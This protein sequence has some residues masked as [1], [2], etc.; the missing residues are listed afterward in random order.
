MK[1]TRAAADGYPV[2]RSEG[3]AARAVEDIARGSY[4]RLVAYLASVS[5]DIAAAEDALSEAFVAA[6]RSWPE[7]GVPDRPDSWLVTAA[8]RTL[9]DAARRRSVAQRGL[10]Q[11]AALLDPEPSDGAPDGSPAAGGGVIPDKRLELMFACTHPAIDPWMRAPL[12]LQ[13]VLGI[14]AGRI[15]AAFLVP[16]ATMGQRL[17]RAKAK[18]KTAAVPFTVPPADQLAGRLS[19]VL[20]AVFAAYGTGWD[21]LDTQ[22]P[23][24]GA[25]AGLTGEALRLATV[26]TELLPGSAEAHGLRALLL[27]SDARAD[28]RRSADGAFVPLD[29]QDVSLWS[30]AQMADAEGHLRLALGLN[31]PAPQLGPYQLQ[32]AVQSVHNRRALTGATDWAAVAALYDG[33]VALTPTVGACVARATA[34][35]HTRGPAAAIALLEELPAELVKRYQP[36]WVVL[37]HC[38][39]R[40]GD[41]AGATAAA[42]TAIS[43]TGDSPVRRHLQAEYGCGPP[44]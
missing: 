36:Y 22:A 20:D 44:R 38:R 14:E 4:G 16:A 7:R 21:D 35:R 18:I 41:P 19:S 26:I 32:A 5:G 31:R 12:M 34:V 42:A 3:T 15:G 23:A 6:L 8:R 37:A 9:V 1:T 39:A 2:P 33:L 17:V 13:A 11:I 28:A 30:R 25:G 29:Q 10:L 27:H 40:S 24:G 43:L